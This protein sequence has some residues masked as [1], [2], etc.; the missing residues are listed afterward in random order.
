[1][2]PCIWKRFSLVQPSDLENGSALCTLLENRSVLFIFFRSKKLFWDFRSGCNIS[3]IKKICICDIMYV[4]FHLSSICRNQV[5][6]SDVVVYSNN[7]TW[8][9]CFV[10]APEDGQI[11]KR[12]SDV[13]NDVFLLLL[14]MI[15]FHMFS[16]NLGSKSYSFNFRR[17]FNSDDEFLPFS[18]CWLMNGVASSSF[19]EFLESFF[20]FFN[21]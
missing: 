20:I 8:L 19:C 9:A 5:C 16:V 4:W 18:F 12:R 11:K 10:S 1:M 15:I 3:Y 7:K 13:T 14:E 21:N 6:S 2:Q 17:S